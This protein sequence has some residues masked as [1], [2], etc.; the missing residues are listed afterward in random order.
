[1]NV[2][3]QSVPGDVSR[4]VVAVVSTVGV[5]QAVND[6][7]PDGAT[8]VKLEV[9]IDGQTFGI[10]GKYATYLLDYLSNAAALSRVSYDYAV[11]TSGKYLNLSILRLRVLSPEEETIPF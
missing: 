1:M 7:S 11:E 3:K 6:V 4:Q 8:Y 9:L 5:L 10:I 2:N